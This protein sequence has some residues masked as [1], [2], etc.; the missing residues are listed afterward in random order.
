MCIIEKC[1]SPLT[2]IECGVPQGSVL[3]TSEIFHPIN[4][5]FPLN[6][7]LE[8]VICLQILVFMCPMHLMAMLFLTPDFC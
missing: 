1:I 8:L 4:V 5:A 7:I 3:N 6:V 2:Y